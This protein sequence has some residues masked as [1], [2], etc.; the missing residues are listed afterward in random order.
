[1]SRQLSPTLPFRPRGLADICDHVFWLLQWPQI[2]D[3]KETLF[4]YFIGNQKGSLIKSTKTSSLQKLCGRSSIRVTER[5]K[6]GPTRLSPPKGTCCFASLGNVFCS[7]KEHV[8]G[9]SGL[10]TRTTLPE[11][12]GLISGSRHQTTERQNACEP[13]RVTHLFLWKTYSIITNPP[14]I[15]STAT[16]SAMIRWMKF[17]YVAADTGGQSVVT[18]CTSCS[19]RF[20]FFNH[21]AGSMGGGWEENLTIPAMPYHELGILKGNGIRN[22]RQNTELSEKRQSRGQLRS[23]PSFDF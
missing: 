10:P 21:S 5:P 9:K 11:T 3:F 23:I 7:Y 20:F 13:H 16:G 12:V 8:I 4:L 6:E 19:F 22:K 17:S 15:S 14:T 2:R 18:L 1:M